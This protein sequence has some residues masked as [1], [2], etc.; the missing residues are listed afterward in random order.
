MKIR[1]ALSTVFSAVIVVACGGGGS[2]DSLKRFAA[3]C[4]ASTNLGKAFCECAA[5]NARDELSAEGFAFLAASFDGDEEELAKLREKLGPAEAI[6]ASMF[7][8]N[9]YKKCAP[10]EQ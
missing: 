9:A 1:K 5:K 10:A 7:M 2:D 3:G 8:V 6:G 4:D